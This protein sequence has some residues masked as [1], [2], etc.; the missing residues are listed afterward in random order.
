MTDLHPAPVPDLSE[1]WIAARR[2]VLVDALSQKPRA[3]AKW[4]AAAGAA[5]VTAIAAMVATI[6]LAG[7]NDR[8]TPG[9]L[10]SAPAQAI[11]YSFAGWSAAPTTP[12]Q[13]QVQNADAVCQARLSQLRPSNKGTAPGSL[14]PELTDVRGPY[15]VTLYGNR[16]PNAALCV[17]ASGSTGLRWITRS[18]ATTPVGGIVVDQV[19][20]LARVGQPYTLVEGRTGTRV[21]NVVL[22][23]GNGSK[24]TATSGEG[25]FIA[26]W[27]GSQSITSAMVT[28]ATGVST[29]ALHLA[30]P[31]IPP[32]TKQ[33]PTSAGSATSERVAPAQGTVH[34]GS[35]G[36]STRVVHR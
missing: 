21:T 16:T 17:S 25:V 22:A 20:V 18:A 32:A 8:A 29:Q 3:R 14:A 2:T 27:P 30:R 34:L 15:T 31:G 11:Q 4:V 7:G 33:A 36:D 12:A 10:P 26:W 35:S 6:V 28:T 23:L 5:S 1:E 19:S 13:G 9:R 24:V